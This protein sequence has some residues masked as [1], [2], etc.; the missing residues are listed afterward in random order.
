MSLITMQGTCHKSCHKSG[1]TTRKWSRLWSFSIAYATSLA[2]DENPSLCSFNVPIM[3]KQLV[4]YFEKETMYP[5]SKQ[6]KRSFKIQK[7]STV[8][9]YLLFML[10]SMPI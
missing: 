5:F 7:K 10:Y 1:A 6:H 9:Q 2:F 8:T 3:R 4:S